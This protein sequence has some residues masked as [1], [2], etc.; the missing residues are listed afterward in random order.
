MEDIPK[1]ALELGMGDWGWETF[2]EWLDYAETLEV[3]LAPWAVRPA[4]LQQAALVS[5]RKIFPKKAARPAGSW[6]HGPAAAGLGGLRLRRA[7]RARRGA[8]RVISD[9]HFAVQLNHFIPGFLSYSVAVC[10]K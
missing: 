10:R 9:C 1:A 8:H 5:I 4:I 7:D 2:P 6:R 3:A